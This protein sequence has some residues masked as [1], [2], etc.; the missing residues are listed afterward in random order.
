MKQRKHLKVVCKRL[1]RARSESYAC[2]VMEMV[3][4][5]CMYELV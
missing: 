5:M 1:A 3:S 2:T 4:V